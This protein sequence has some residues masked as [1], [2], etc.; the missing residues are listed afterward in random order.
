MLTTLAGRTFSCL[1]T[2][3]HYS[4][5]RGPH[6]GPLAMAMYAI[7]I[8]PWF[9][10]SNLSAPAKQ[11]WFADDATAGEQLHRP[12]EWW[13]KQC[14]QRPSFGYFVTPSKML[15]IVKEPHLPIAM[16]LLVGTGVSIMTDG[17]QHWGSPLGPRPFVHNYVRTR[18]NK[19]VASINLQK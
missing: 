10:N 1:S 13:T 14:N 12:L 7:G 18:V 2:E 15:L 17:R 3:K 19:W 4:H 11:V 5:V 16:E 9:T 8:L 6:K